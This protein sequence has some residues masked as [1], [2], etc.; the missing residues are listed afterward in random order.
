MPSPAGRL[1]RALQHRNF[2]LFFGGQSVSLV[3][4]WITRVATSWL[5]YRLTGSEL[6]LG[7]AGFAGQIPT[8]VITPFAGVLVDRHDRRR[9]L[10]VTQ[11]ASLVQSAVLAVLTFTNVITVKQIIWLQVVQGVINSFD[12]PARQAFVSEMV[13]DRRD[14]PNAI[15]LN[16]S[17]VN[18]TRIIGPSIGGLLIAGFGEA[19]CF[20]VDSISYVAV[21]GSIVAMRVPPRARHEAAEMHLLD[22][23][24]HGW[25]YVLHSV[26][27]RSALLLVA[28]VCAAG[29]PYTVLMPAIAKKVFHGGPNTLG[30]L[31]TGTGVGALAGALYLAQRESVLGLGRII[32][33]ASVVFG[34]GLVVFSQLTSLWLS[35]V[36]LAIAGCGFMIHLAATN[37]IL[38]TIVEERLRGRVMSFY[39]MAF[40]GTVP[41][42]SL[43]GGVMADR[44]GA[45]NTVLAS[46]IACIAGSAWF[47]YKLPAIRAVIRPIYRERGIITVPAVDTGGKTL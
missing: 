4:T 44:Y 11:A 41:I 18:G 13:E 17:M 1:T 25:K 5:V 30:L 43:I 14:L 2:R 28:I 9:I 36:V 3:G 16:S 29:T 45:P 27:I 8:L 35:F 33:W 23:L 32:M 7:I 46:G 19:W 10:L 34:I 22:E 6:L 12:T 31:M 15:A 38:Q 37:T 47:A 39:T 40:F 20:A 42:G 21:I 26:P 24:H